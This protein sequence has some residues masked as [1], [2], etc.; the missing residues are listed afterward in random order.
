MLNNYLSLCKGGSPSPKKKE[1]TRYSDVYVFTLGELSDYRKKQQSAGLKNI[2]SLNNLG[3]I[4][5]YTFPSRNNK[6]ASNVSFTAGKTIDFSSSYFDVDNSLGH[7]S[8]LHC[9]SYRDKSAPLKP[10]MSGYMNKRK[11]R[12]CYSSQGSVEGGD[13]NLQRNASRKSYGPFERLREK[14]DSDFTNFIKRHRFSSIMVG[15]KAYEGRNGDYYLKNRQHEEYVLN[16]IDLM[17]ESI[18]GSLNSST[19]EAC[20]V[21]KNLKPAVKYKSVSSTTVSKTGTLPGHKKKPSNGISIKENINVIRVN[22]L[23][24]VK[25]DLNNSHAQQHVKIIEKI[26]TTQKRSQN[27]TP[28]PLKKKKALPSKVDEVEYSQAERSAVLIRRI[29]YSQGIKGSARDAEN[30]YLQLLYETKCIVIQRWWKRMLVRLFVLNRKATSVQKVFR[31]YIVRLAIKQFKRLIGTIIPFLEQVSYAVNKRR[32]YNAF[33]VLKI[34]KAFKFYH[35]YITKKAIILQKCYRAFVTRKEQRYLRYKK[36]F[37]LLFR[38]SLEYFFD[39][40]RNNKKLKSLKAIVRLQ[41]CIRKWLFLNDWRKLARINP[42]FGLFRKYNFQTY[43]RKRSI[44]MKAISKFRNLYMTRKCRRMI[45]TFSKLNRA[46]NFK[47]FISQLSIHMRSLNRVNHISGIMISLNP[48]I[49][50]TYIRKSFRKWRKATRLTKNYCILGIRLMYKAFYQSPWNTLNDHML[51][52]NNDKIQVYKSSVIKRLYNTLNKMILR[53]FFYNVKSRFD[54]ASKIEAKLLSILKYTSKRAKERAFQMFKQNNIE[55]KLLHSRFKEAFYKLSRLFYNNVIG[56]FRQNIHKHNFTRQMGFGSKDI[57]VLKILGKLNDFKNVRKAFNKL[58]KFNQKESVRSMNDRLKALHLSII[59]RIVSQ[60]ESLNLAL[61]FNR[62]KN[63]AGKLT[64]RY[65]H[66]FDVLTRL[67]R[68]A[69]LSLMKNA[70]KILYQTTITEKDKSAKFALLLAKIFDRKVE[71]IKCGVFR[72][73]FQRYKQDNTKS[74]LRQILI[75]KLLSLKINTDTLKMSK[76]FNQWERN[77]KITSIMSKINEENMLDIKAKNENKRIKMRKNLLLSLLTKHDDEAIQKLRKSFAKLIRFSNMSRRQ[78]DKLSLILNILSRKSL[79]Q[80][81]V[82]FI[83]WNLYAMSF[84]RSNSLRTVINIRNS[85]VLHRHFMKWLKALDNQGKLYNLIILSSLV[86]NKLTSRRLHEV[87]NSWYNRTVL[88]RKFDIVRLRY[89]K[90]IERFVD[91]K[92]YKKYFEKLKANSLSEKRVIHLK[93]L[94]ANKQSSVLFYYFKLWSYNLRFELR[95]MLLNRLGSMIYE[96][97]IHVYLMRWRNTMSYD[98]IKTIK[99]HNVRPKSLVKYERE[100]TDERRKLSLL[101]TIVLRNEAFIQKRLRECFDKMMKIKGGYFRKVL[102]KLGELYT[103]NLLKEI[104]LRKAE[105]DGLMLSSALM[106]FKRFATYTAIDQNAKIIQNLIKGKF[107]PS[108]SSK[109]LAQSTCPIIYKHKHNFENISYDTQKK[110]LGLLLQDV[111]AN[112]EELAYRI[113]FHSYR[114]FINRLKRIRA[115]PVFLDV[116]NMK[117]IKPI[118]FSLATLVMNSIKIHFCEK[119]LRENSSAKVIKSFCMDILKKMTA[120]SIAAKTIQKWYINRKVIRQAKIEL[121]ARIIQD[122]CKRKMKQAGKEDEF[123]RLLNKKHEMKKL[124]KR[125]YFNILRRK[126]MKMKLIS[127]INKLIDYFR[128][129]KIYSKNIT[130]FRMKRTLRSLLTR[131]LINHIHRSMRCFKFIY[132]LKL[133]SGR[134]FLGRVKQHNIVRELYK[135]GNVF[136][137][138]ILNQLSEG[139]KMNHSLRFI[140]IFWRTRSKLR[141]FK[142]M[143]NM[144]KTHIFRINLLDKKKLNIGFNKLLKHALKQKIKKAAALINHFM[145]T[146]AMKKRLNRIISQYIPRSIKNDLC[147][148]FNRLAAIRRQNY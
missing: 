126:I 76:G 17:K 143:R 39:E 120:L 88:I 11:M 70:I 33:Q 74:K 68:T 63:T 41:S 37:V 47:Y 128:F 48:L 121:D 52:N 86:M 14:L 97:A 3:S 27:L 90:Y 73:V 113:K 38:H 24:K 15:S 117:I 85:I 21:P 98:R 60:H 144:L 20:S 66:A 30:V 142:N 61:Y 12:K 96:K 10:N 13:R 8:S 35:D 31:G 65:S 147:S 94:L 115:E 1:N 7:S 83:K 40:L 71:E 26:S 18:S 19:I 75:S 146:L 135:L 51:N 28:I 148:L 101:E 92:V 138:G 23:S 124:Y 32:V 118:K 67:F 58:N 62:L 145:Y 91:Q 99:L 140:Q 95:L 22:K 114:M 102:E 16:E 5:K 109:A 137:R 111:S 45:R 131:H 53:T 132:L 127:G 116:L 84:R 44:V 69:K 80:L 2:S 104:V 105:R 34:K 54:V 72:Q 129:R 46:L 122:Y 107:V 106:K 25:Q 130:I 112:I 43:M 133:T 78:S 77:A 134:Y 55:L 100:I 36:K 87:V 49:F 81:K 136:K 125:L 103:G 119:T 64:L 59:F 141:A 6:F 9:L 93:S 79:G 29:E 123:V 57:S 56:Y 4:A 110:L 42:L 82:T 50:N 139:V 89:L 108:V